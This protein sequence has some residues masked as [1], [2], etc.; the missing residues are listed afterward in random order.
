MVKFIDTKI[1]TMENREL[2]FNVYRV[3]VFQ[4][5]NVLEMDSGNGYIARW[6]YLPPLSCTLKLI[7]MVNVMFMYT[8][9]Q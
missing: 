7:K 3:L 5:K 8:L 4:D 9:Q 2:L 1:R 6:M